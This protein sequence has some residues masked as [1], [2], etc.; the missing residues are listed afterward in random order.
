MASG[1][2]G[3]RR[4]K[5][6]AGHIDSTAR[7]FGR[8]VLWRFV[9]LAAFDLALVFWLPDHPHCDLTGVPAIWWALAPPSL[10]LTSGAFRQATQ[11]ETPAQGADLTVAVPMFLAAIGLIVHSAYRFC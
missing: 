4:R 2:A 5:R 6:S 11:G 10:M 9:C 8:A 3:K 1:R 7:R